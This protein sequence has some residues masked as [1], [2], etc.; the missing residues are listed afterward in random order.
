VFTSQCA[1]C[2]GIYSC[3]TLI[4]S[5]LCI[6]GCETDGE[7]RSRAGEL[8]CPQKLRCS[9]SIKRLDG[10]TACD[11]SRTHGPADTLPHS[12]VINRGNCPVR[13]GPRYS[14]RSLS[15]RWFGEVPGRRELYLAIW[16]ALR[17]GHCWIHRN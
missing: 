13:N 7:R 8:C 5:L 6:R 12:A 15:E 1:R 3:P 14:N 4:G 2:D 10:Q 17:I 16:G 11:C 9:L